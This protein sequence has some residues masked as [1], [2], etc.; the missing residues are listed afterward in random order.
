M[1]ETVLVVEYG[2]IDN[3][4][5]TLIPYASTTL[6]T[7]DMFNLTSAPISGLNNAQYPVYIGSMV[8]GGSLVNGMEFDRAAAADYDAW[9]SLGNPGW[10]WDGLLPYFKKS[11]TFTPPAAALAQEYNIT[12]DLSAYGNGPVQSTISPYLYTDLKT[13]LQAWNELSV[14]RPV[15]GANGEIGVIWT[16][17]STDPKTM[18]R[19]SAR[20]A[21]YDP[22]TARPNLHL[23][24]GSTVNQII[25][26]SLT[27]VGVKYISKADG[28]TYSA[29]AAKEVV[30][31]AGAVHTPQIL[32]LSGI[33][34]K[35]VIQAAQL[36]L[37]LDL[38]AVGANFQDHPVAYI[39]Y[40]CR[41]YP[42]CCVSIS[43]TD[44]ESSHQECVLPKP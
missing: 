35:K 3:G 44:P 29:Y 36:D 32:Q 9:E 33:G 19:S 17:C 34:P 22:I 15:D 10:G 23:L 26:N 8:G 14:P 7:A 2:S 6:N 42:L 20:T 41:L 5:T 24:T 18:T 37:R 12:W 25:F 11:S 40:T 28:R 39:S 27:A 21:Y 38:P 31:A 16:P 30:M 4:S 1:I 13:E 43:G